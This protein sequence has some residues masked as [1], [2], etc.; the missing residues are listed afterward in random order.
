ML[1]QAS[2]G[3]YYWPASTAW[4]WAAQ[5]SASARSPRWLA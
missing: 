2:M 4:A 3:W 1:A 5:R